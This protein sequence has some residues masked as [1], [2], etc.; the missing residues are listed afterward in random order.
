MA[1]TRDAVT[2]KFCRDYLGLDAERE[3]ALVSRTQEPQFC[4]EKT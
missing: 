2:C 4:C 1:K 3:P